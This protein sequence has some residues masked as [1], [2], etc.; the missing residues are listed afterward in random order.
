VV[1]LPAAFA[2][3]TVLALAGAAVTAHRAP[4]GK[5][6]FVRSVKHAPTP[7]AMVAD[8]RAWGLKWVAIQS[9]W[10]LPGNKTKAH[11]LDKIPAYAR[12]LERAGVK[13]WIWSWPVPG[14][15]HEIAEVYQWL[16][17]KAK[18]RGLILDP[19]QPYQAKN[20]NLLGSMEAIASLDVSMLQLLDVPLGCTTY[21]APPSWHPRFP[22][23]AWSRVTFGM[24]QLYDT[25]HKWGAEHQRATFRGWHQRGF[26]ALVPVWGASQAHS[27]DQMREEINQTPTDFRGACWWDYYWIRKSKRRAAVVANYRIR[28]AAVA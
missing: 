2:G 23:T 20:K 21:G 7:A 25:Y 5:G 9:I 19:E 17:R 8:C 10:Q 14:R 4:A 13:A 15:A 24:P 6:V 12:A 26:S 22:W 28:K 27:P 18:L 11:H 1:A 3:A 16:A